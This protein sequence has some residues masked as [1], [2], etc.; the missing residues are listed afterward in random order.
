MKEYGW[1]RCILVLVLTIAITGTSQAAPGPEPGTE[2]QNLMVN[3]DFSDGTT[4]WELEV[5]G[6]ATWSIVNGEA[7]VQIA[8]GGNSATSIQLRQSGLKI[9]KGKTYQVSFE[10]YADAKRSIKADVIRNVP[11]Y[12]AYSRIKTFRL[13]TT[14]TRYSFQFTMDQNMDN[15]ARLRFGLGNSIIGV[16]IDNVLIREIPDEQDWWNGLEE[17]LDEF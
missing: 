9:E 11:Q 15:D 6:V 4:G 5:T 1:L 17:E 13:T 14:K 16:R 8:D 10:A 12:N 3:G 2:G 7:D